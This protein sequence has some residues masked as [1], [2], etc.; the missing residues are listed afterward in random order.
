MTVGPEVEFAAYGRMAIFAIVLVAGWRVRRRREHWPVF[1]AVAFVLAA[2]VA[3]LAG[4]LLLSGVLGVPFAGLTAWV[5]VRSM[6][7]RPD[8]IAAMLAAKE[9]AWSRERHDLR[10]DLAVERGRSDLLQREI[11]AQRAARRD[12]PNEFS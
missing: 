10:H 4:D 5:F 11:D 3:L 8:A 1:A 12:G 6:T 2:N 9:S 7:S